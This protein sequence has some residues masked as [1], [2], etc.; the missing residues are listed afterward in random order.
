MTEISII[1]LGAMGTAL[2]R[3]Q[4]GGGYGVTVWNRTAAKAGPLAADGATVAATAPEAVLASPFTLIC[5]DSYAVTAEILAPL[6]A[7]DL[8][9]RILVQLSTGTSKEARDGAARVA[10]RGGATLDG[11]LMCYPAGIGSPD[12]TILIGGPETAFRSARAHLKLLG[13]DLQYLGDNV[14]AAAAIDLGFLMMIVSLSAGIAQAARICEAEGADLARLAAL[15]GFEGVA[16][17]QLEVIEKGAFELNS[18]HS[19]ATLGVWTNAI[20]RLKAQAE[21]AGTDAQLPA[22]LLDFYR[23]AVDL[24]HGDED[25]AALVKLVRQPR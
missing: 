18:L 7:T 3:A 16:A 14:A 24:G 2:A 10:E 25:L 4:M 15:A 22:F 23:Q 5:V 21:D 12:T 13:G 11:A 1:G 9:G 20:R 6:A 19:G 8:T 17:R